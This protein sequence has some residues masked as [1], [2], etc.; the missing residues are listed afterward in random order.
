MTFLLPQN[1]KA[2]TTKEI[3]FAG[4]CFWGVQE[5]FSR[6]PGVLKTTS[7]YA[8]GMKA[9][10]TYK[11][12]CT[13]RTGHAE[14]VRVE[15]DPQ[16]VSLKTLATQFFA[17]IDPVSVNRQ[18]NDIGTQYRTGMYYTDESDK[19]ILEKVK[20]SEQTKYKKQL[21]V[22]L[23]ALTSFY[24]A[25]DYHQDY[26]KKNPYGYCHISFDSLKNLPKEDISISVD[27]KKYSK[28]DKDTLKSK[29]SAIEYNVTQNG[30]TELAF[31]GKLWNMK[32]KGIYVDIVT[33][34]PLFLS[35]DKFESGTGWPS[36]TKPISPEVIQE[37]TDTSYGMLRTEVRS[38]VGN[39][40][41]G[42]VFDD[43]PKKTGG[44]RYCINSASLR[45][46]PF[47]E[48]ESAGYGEFI[49]LFQ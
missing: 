24:P 49:P 34:E 10:P 3:Y 29:L 11:E 5:Y 8:N 43:G 7:G 40:H 37:K 20:E 13:G 46:I 39:S 9:N 33:G 45:F 19:K 23:L 4:G 12:V 17:I 6:I 42:H 31:T 30:A 1:L 15:Y 16:R 47:K 21:A 32:E 22:E 27:P 14:T 44:L 18:G 41:L 36:F 48:M 35:T 2:S 26:L 38:R 25:E 28:P